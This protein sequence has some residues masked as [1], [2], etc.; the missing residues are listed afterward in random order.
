MGLTRNNFQS[1]IPRINL[2]VA[3]SWDDGHK[4]DMRVADLLK[5]YGLSGTF[6][7]T[8]D[9]VGNDDK[10]TWKEI[11]QIQRE[12]G[13]EI[14]SH[15]MTHPSDLKKL[16]EEELFFELQSSK[17]LIES[18]LGTTI[19]KFCYPRGRYNEAVMEQLAKAGYIEA[20]TTLVGHLEEPKDKL[21]THTTVHVF[22]GRGE[23]KQGD[24]VKFAN[25]KLE[26]A[27]KDPTNSIFHLW[28][29]SWEVDKGDEWE[30]LENFFKDLTKKV[31]V[32]NV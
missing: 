22:D 28:G 17:D 3:T 32:Q 5:K 12:Y 21:Q 26:E 18:V 23:Y 15:T 29:H 25:E 24:W 7:I 8:V 16:Y 4:L 30:N 19:T 20:R 27:I 13:F 2:R 11:K 1:S 9:H 10:L 14:G 31:Q 6:Y